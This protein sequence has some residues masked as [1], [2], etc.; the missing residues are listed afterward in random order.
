[1]PLYWDYLLKWAA[2]PL[3]EPGKKIGVMPLIYGEQ[4]T[5]KSLF[6][7]ALLGALYGPLKMELNSVRLLLGGFNFHLGGILY[8]VI[9]EAGLSSCSA[10]DRNKLKNMI[11]Q[12]T[13]VRS[14]Q[15]ILFPL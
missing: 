10:E 11:T 15:Q 12:P 8:V 2:A 5:G 4:G 7:N 1:M 6:L 14:Q 9:D 3:Q 13:W